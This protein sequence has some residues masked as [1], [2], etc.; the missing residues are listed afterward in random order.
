MTIEIWEKVSYRKRCEC[1]RHLVPKRG[2][3]HR[4]SFFSWEEAMPIVSKKARRRSIAIRQFY[5]SRFH[6]KGRVV[7]VLVGY[8]ANELK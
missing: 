5:S 8:R 7:Q 6:H 4:G 2:S 1:G 3:F